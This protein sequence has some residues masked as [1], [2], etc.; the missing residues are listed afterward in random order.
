MQMLYAN[1]KHCLKQPLIVGEEM[2]ECPLTTKEKIIKVTM[3]I[4]A[5]EGVQNLTIRK[6]AAKA[7]VNVA[8]VN[9]HFGSKDGAIDAALIEVTNELRQAFAILQGE[10]TDEEER[11]FVFINKYTEIVNKY[12]DIIKN[13]INRAMHNK[14]LDKQ[15][16]YMAFLKNEGIAVL[17]ETIGRINPEQGED[18][19]YLLT[20]HLMSCLCFPFLLGA[21]GQEIMGVD[22]CNDRIRQAHTRLLFQNV[23]GGANRCQLESRAGQS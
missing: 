18:Q 12:P 16:E 22:L 7:V 15:I 8:A 4:I 6:I 21:Q 9:Y 20:L 11:L 13:M 14:P 19:L 1:I 2:T 23:I 10:D 17:K 3:D 5:T